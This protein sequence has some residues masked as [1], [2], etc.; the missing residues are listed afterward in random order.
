MA[1]TVPDIFALGAAIGFFASSNSFS[2][3]SFFGCLSATVFSSAV[4]FFDIKQSFLLLRINVK[5]P[6]QNFLINRLALGSGCA[7][8]LTH[9][10]FP[11][12]I[13]S[14]LFFGLPFSSK[15]FFTEYSLVAS[16]PSP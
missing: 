8:P 14:G 12:W 7:M 9:E 1:L 3:T 2:A 15:S 11:T 13:I 6:G 4:A 10:A 16:A 5:G